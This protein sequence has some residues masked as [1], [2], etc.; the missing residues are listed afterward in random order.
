MIFKKKKFYKVLVC[1]IFLVVFFTNLPSTIYSAQK[2]NDYR[3]R[4]YFKRYTDYNKE[5]QQMYYH[6]YIPENY[7]ELLAY[8]LVIYLSVVGQDVAVN[9]GKYIDTT[10]LSNG[11][12]EEFPCII[13]IPK[14]PENYYWVENYYGEISPGL[15][16][17]MS[18]IDSICEEYSVDQRKIYITGLC[19]NATG[20]WDALF[21]FPEK[22]AAGVVVANVAPVSLAS[23]VTDV[24]LWIFNS[25]MDQLV[26]VVDSREMAKA[27]RK[28]GNSHVI[29]TEYKGYDHVK[30]SKAPFYERDLF[31]WMFSQTNQKAPFPE[32]KIPIADYMS[33]PT[34]KDRLY[35]DN[36]TPTKDETIVLE[37]DTESLENTLNTDNK[38]QYSSVIRHNN[39]RLSLWHIFIIILG[40]VCICILFILLRK[41]CKKIFCLNKTEGRQ[42]MNKKLVIVFMLIAFILIGILGCSK[43][44]NQNLTT[45]V[46]SSPNTIVKNPNDI[47]LFSFEESN[48]FL[49]SLDLR[50][51]P[52]NQLVVKTSSTSSFVDT[53]KG[54]KVHLDNLDNVWFQVL[55]ASTP[56]A[57]KQNIDNY[58]YLRVWVSNVG[59]GTLT[60]G[61]LFSAGMYYYSFLDAENA[62]VTTSDGVELDAENVF[63]VDKFIPEAVEHGYDSV[64]L[65]AGF[66]GWVAFPISA[67]TV[68]YWTASPIDDLHNATTIDLRILSEPQ[69]TAFY[70]IDDICLTDNKQGTTRLD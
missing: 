42:N 8:P 26:S 30:A 55:R 43:N 7:D 15:D 59:E 44:K 33:D 51:A 2:D 61:I 37:E 18:M 11:N 14:L 20:V 57:Y 6:L 66:S 24:P 39:K 23:K 45:L 67:D 65:P 28:A 10:I 41:K 40:A 22:F 4:Y 27:L 16:L 25:D 60:L 47:M 63:T 35:V 13:L 19:S 48:N 38:N 64:V 1:F 62:I 32:N 49:Q 46:T 12:D 34:I 3:P 5:L 52:W 36:N 53:G 31:P 29:Y 69:K 50:N 70:V 9:S 68:N 58:K 17:L 21:R 56:N 54:L